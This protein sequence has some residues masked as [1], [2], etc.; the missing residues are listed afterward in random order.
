MRRSRQVFAGKHGLQVNI[1]DPLDPLSNFNVFI[2]DEM[3]DAIVLETNRKASQLT[4]AARRGT[5]RS[6][7]N[8]WVDASELREFIAVLFYQTLIHKA[9]QEMYWSTKPL[10][11][12]P[13][14]RQVMSEQRFSLLMKYIL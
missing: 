4:A 8:N 5:R 14:I 11:E 10:L 1:A 12:T 6:R 2:T 3:L 9:E 13:Y 7:L